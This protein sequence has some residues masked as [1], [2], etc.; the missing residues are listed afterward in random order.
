MPYLIN[1]ETA[2]ECLHLYDE[3]QQLIS[4]PCS[5]KLKCRV[6]SATTI[7]KHKTKC[8]TESNT[9]TKFH[10]M[11]LYLLHA[12]TSDPLFKV[13]CLASYMYIYITYTYT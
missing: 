7:D 8:K 4:F 11:L 3:A 5:Y 12:K 6:K 2:L 1:F 9:E 13:L 10:Q